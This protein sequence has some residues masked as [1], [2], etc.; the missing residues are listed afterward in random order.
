M[1]INTHSHPPHSTPVVF[2]SRHLLQILLCHQCSL[3]F[4]SHPM[5]FSFL[6][7]WRKTSSTLGHSLASTSVLFL[8]SLQISLWS[9]RIFCNHIPPLNLFLPRSM[10]THKSE[11]PWFHIFI[12]FVIYVAFNAADRRVCIEFLSSYF[13]ALISPINSRSS[14]LTLFFHHHL[15][16]VFQKS[17]QS[18]SFLPMFILLLKGFTHP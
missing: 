11:I 13:M 2:I 10:M 15:H 12:P 6:S 8:L 14:W 4:L 9:F 18:P 16:T 7:S 5:C 17:F 1:Y 3:L